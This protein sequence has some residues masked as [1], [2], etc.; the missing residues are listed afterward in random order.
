MIARNTGVRLRAKRIHAL[1]VEELERLLPVPEH[2]LAVTSSLGVGHCLAQQLTTLEE[3]V[4]KR[5]KHTSAYAQLQT[6]HGIGP[7][8]AQ[9]IVLETGDI[10]RFP[11]V[12]HYASYCRCVGSTK[13]SKGKQQGQGHV[14]NGNPYL[15]WAYMS[16]G[17]ER[18]C[19]LAG[20]F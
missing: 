19:L 11:T 12:G 2:V 13:I 1:T 10:S 8:V 14:K 9:M 16:G 18:G 20:A 6:V 7:I 5:L 3:T 17:R 15:A 4:Q